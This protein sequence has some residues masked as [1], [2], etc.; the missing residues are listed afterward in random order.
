[1]VDNLY[2]LS[3]TG[4]GLCVFACDSPC[5]VVTVDS[6]LLLMPQNAMHSSPRSE[7]ICNFSISNSYR[8]HELIHFLSRHYKAG[9]RIQCSDR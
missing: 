7:C 8:S 2:F 3:V 1:M 6:I 9:R 5:S 4:D